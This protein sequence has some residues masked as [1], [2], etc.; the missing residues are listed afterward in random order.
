MK[1]D[2]AHLTSQE[3]SVV[4]FLNEIALSTIS[5]QGISALYK[6]NGYLVSFKHGDKDLHFYL[7]AEK[8]VELIEL[9]VGEI[10][11]LRAFVSDKKE[12]NDILFHHWKE[13]L[14]YFNLK[15]RLLLA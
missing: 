13:Y 14:N 15:I 4:R 12:V 2:Y 1:I 6:G 3:S 9:K 5:F 11:T 10:I 8:T 7:N